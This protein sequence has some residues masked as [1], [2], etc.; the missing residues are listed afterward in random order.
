MFLLIY[1]LIFPLYSIYGSYV[2]VI[3]RQNEKQ[4]VRPRRPLSRQPQPPSDI[5]VEMRIKNTSTRFPRT[6]PCILYGIQCCGP[7]S[8]IGFFRIPDL[9]PRIPDPKPINDK[10]FGKKCY[11]NNCYLVFWLNKFSSPVQKKK[12]FSIL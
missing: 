1:V 9:G 5:T 6:L 8:G 3:F 10:F 7:E 4:A 2:M 12:I 11:N